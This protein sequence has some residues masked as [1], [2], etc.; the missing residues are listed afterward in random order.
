[1]NLTN[2]YLF[3]SR[4][5]K[6]CIFCF[7]PCNPEE[8]VVAHTGGEGHP[9]H[10]DCT[11]T[12][13]LW[14][15]RCA[16]CQSPVDPQ[17][18]NN[19]LTWKEKCIAWVKPFALDSLLSVGCAGA[20]VTTT[21]LWDRTMGEIS[22]T[23]YIGVLSSTAMGLIGLLFADYARSFC[24]PSYAAIGGGIVGS[25]QLMEHTTKYLGYVE[26]TPWLYGML[27]VCNPES[28]EDAFSTTCAIPLGSQLLSKG[29]LTCQAMPV[30]LEAFKS[31]FAIPVITTSA[32]MGTF[33]G[34][35]GRK[36]WIRP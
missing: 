27:S 21:F 24:F 17:S 14:A 22:Y 15:Q 6:N 20:I 29:F 35:L 5:D 11:K 30:G 8:K 1:M 10:R 3:Q 32:L 12:M 9:S 23:P 33:G 31:Q 16:V 36:F 18:L 19:C 34:W 13:M 28:I 25:W 4:E 7:A 26:A 2:Y